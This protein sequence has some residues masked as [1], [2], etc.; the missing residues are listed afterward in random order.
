M[1]GDSQ[2]H[3]ERPEDGED[4]NVKLQW[5]DNLKPVSTVRVAL[6]GAVAIVTLFLPLVKAF[7]RQANA[8]R[9]RRSW[10]P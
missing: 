5:L 7:L 1:T 9:R 10:C 3:G 6:T 8:C 2:V 4:L